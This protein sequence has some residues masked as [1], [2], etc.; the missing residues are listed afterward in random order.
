VTGR[1]LSSTIARNSLWVGLDTSFGI[2]VS[3]VVSITAARLLG[4]GKL[5]E[6]NFIVWVAGLTALLVQFGVP[7]A[8]TRFAGEMVGQGKSAQ[9]LGL[10]AATLRLQAAFAFVV[11]AAALT[12][13][14]LFAPPTQ[15]LYAS[16][17]ILSLVPQALMGVFTAGIN[18]TENSF[19]NVWPSMLANL[20][21]LSGSVG[22]LVATGSLTLLAAALLASRSVDAVLRWRAFRWAWRQRFGEQTAQPIPPET[23]PAL[24]R[25][26]AQAVALWLLNAV[27]W[28]RSDMLFV[29]LFHDS[30][31]VAFF[32]LSFNL[33]TQTL[34]LPQVLVHAAGVSMGVEQG[35]DPAR[36]GVVAVTLLKYLA[37]VTLPIVWGIAAL[38]PAL[39]PFVYGDEYRAAVPVLAVA[40]TF[41]VARALLGPAQRAL[42]IS[43]RQ[44]ALIRIGLMSGVLNVVLDLTWVPAHAA[45]GAA[46][47]NGVT[48]AVAAV[49]VWS[50]LLRG[51]GVRLPVATLSRLVASAL[52]MALATALL[53]TRVAPAAALITGPV[54][55][56]LLYV[57]MVRWTRALDSSDSS[58]LRALEGAVPTLLR[59]AYAAA[60]RS[61][62]RQ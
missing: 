16:I 37:L 44:G 27:V 61:V 58:R 12:I 33:M 39:I 20:L 48:Q 5:G 19:H 25:F 55:G 62:T 15:R 22:A 1:S 41:A 32:A 51:F 50:V 59:R 10:V 47:A 34:V 28:D 14:W 56:A 30:A 8:T 38:S 53:A 7:A 11:V 26:C 35:R 40:G 54:I 3:A 4:P 29:Q 6:Y 31:E 46:F 36:V 21:L 60:V 9:A 57:G 23:W 52:V 45:V 2:F 13:L 18:A 49:A 42:V 24:R 17:V 43:D